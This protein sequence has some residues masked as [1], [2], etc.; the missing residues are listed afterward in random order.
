VKESRV[1]STILDAAGPA[2]SHF[3]VDHCAVT[4]GY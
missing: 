2:L 1:H 4:A 3:R